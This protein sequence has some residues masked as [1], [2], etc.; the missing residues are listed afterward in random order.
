[1]NSDIEQ[2]SFIDSR[3]AIDYACNDYVRLFS[4]EY[5][6]KIHKED[7]IALAHHFKIKTGDTKN[8]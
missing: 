3:V 8:E 4:D 7:V 1:M 2:Y 6:G 5:I